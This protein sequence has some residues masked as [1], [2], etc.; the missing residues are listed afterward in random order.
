ML[1]GF[2]F[3][4]VHSS[5]YGVRETPTKRILSPLKRRKLI[6]IPG[7][8]DA[9]I[10]EDGGYEPRV[11]SI[12]CSYVL[13]DGANSLEEVRNIAGWLDGVGELTYDYEP[14]L[15]Y[16]AYLSS[17]PPTAA[18]LDFAQFDLEFTMSHP[19]AYETAIQQDE[20][21]GRFTSNNF[22]DVDTDGTVETPVRII[23][24]NLNHATISRL[25]IY[26]RYVGS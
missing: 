20:V 7:R 3:R 13:P 2:T 9:F 15:H 16:N 19:F 1:G 17:P 23:I 25:K 22:A 12:R 10:E 24:Q 26:H 5:V 21:I 18:M 8:S 11:E 6:T 14:N 4:G